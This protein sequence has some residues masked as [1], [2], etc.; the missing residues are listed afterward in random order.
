MPYAYKPLHLEGLGHAFINTLLYLDYDRTGWDYPVVPFQINAYGR[1]MI[2]GKGLTG[3][4]FT[5]ARPSMTR[6]RPSPKRCFEL[7]VA[8]A[9]SCGTAP[10]ARRSSARPAGRTPS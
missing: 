3:R 2:S 9:R 6:R 7:G 10:G 8:V 4:L 1:N 5:A